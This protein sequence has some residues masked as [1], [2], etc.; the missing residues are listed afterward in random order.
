ML[1]N[2][3]VLRE[4]LMA[5]GAFAGIAVFAV[6]AVD[7]MVTGGFDFAPTQASPHRNQPSA[8][9]RVVD[10]AQYVTDRFREVTWNEPQLIDDASAATVDDL[11][12]EDDGSPAPV[13]AGQTSDGDLYAEISTLYEAEPEAAYVEEPSYQDAPATDEYSPEAAEK[14]ASAS[15]TASPW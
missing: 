7:V 13:A 8:Y 15:E 6:A 11:A 10:A 3:P 2:N 9:V 14:L 5:C 4:R 12:G 1:D